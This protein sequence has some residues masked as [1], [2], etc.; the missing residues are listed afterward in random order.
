MSRNCF[1][2]YLWA[3]LV[4]LAAAGSFAVLFM[5]WLGIVDRTVEVGSLE[6]IER[7]IGFDLPADTRLI[8]AKYSGFLIRAELAVKV[9]MPPDELQALLNTPPLDGNTTEHDRLLDNDSAQFADMHGWL[10]DAARQFIAVSAVYPEYQSYI[11]T[12]LADIDQ[13]Q[14]PVVYLRWGFM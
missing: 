9:T 12:I 6:G 14:T 3:V 1:I 10:P 7:R 11:V 4:V 13:P 5:I 2:G 8:E